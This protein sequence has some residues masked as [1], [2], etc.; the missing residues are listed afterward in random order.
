MDA[1]EKIEAAQHDRAPRGHQKALISAMPE[2]GTAL[3]TA[4]L[5]KFRG[6]TQAR[7]A[8]SNATLRAR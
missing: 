4:N 7:Q 8:S 2:P 3:T 1:W 6:T 5:D